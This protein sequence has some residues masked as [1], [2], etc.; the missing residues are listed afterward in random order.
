MQM[1]SCALQPLWILG[2]WSA[3]LLAL[4]PHKYNKERRRTMRKL[5]RVVCLMLLTGVVAFTSTSSFSYI[6][7]S[8]YYVYVDRPCYGYCGY[9]DYGYQNCKWVQGHYDKCGHWVDAQ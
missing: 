1:D 8:G 2:T 7:R 3:Y 4:N 5:A 9:Y 6:N